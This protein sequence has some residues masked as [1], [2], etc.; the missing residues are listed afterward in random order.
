[1]ARIPVRNVVKSSIASISVSKNAI[2]EIKNRQSKKTDKTIQFTKLLIDGEG[3]KDGVL[4]RL[5]KKS[6]F[7]NL[8]VFGKSRYDVRFTPVENEPEKMEVDIQVWHS[9]K[10]KLRVRYTKQTTYDFI[11]SGSSPRTQLEQGIKG[12]VGINPFRRRWLMYVKERE[13]MIKNAIGM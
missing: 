7:V 3:G 8:Q 2:E 1:M 6:P 9:P 12:K 10:G 11:P 5:M 4:L 13:R